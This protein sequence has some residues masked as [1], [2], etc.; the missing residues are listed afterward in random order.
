[1]AC[2]QASF[3]VCV[4]QRHRSVSLG[5]RLRDVGQEGWQLD[6]ASPP[7]V[8]WGTVSCRGAIPSPTHLQPWAGCDHGE[9]WQEAVWG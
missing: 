9:L 8:V 2:A 6:M 1:M 4:S 3:L 7:A 5:T